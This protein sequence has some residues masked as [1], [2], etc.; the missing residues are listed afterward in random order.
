MKRNLITATLASAVLGSFVMAP[1]MADDN[2]V[3]G[4]PASERSMGDA[5]DDAAIVAKVKAAM[6]SSSE[7]EGLDVNVDSRNGIVTLSGSADSMAER[8]QAERI[9]K[10]A[11]GVKSVDNKIVIKADDAP[12]APR[13]APAPAAT[14][15]D[16]TPPAN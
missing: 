8:S 10:T 3:D 13:T 5:M 14:P 4:A 16:V 11:D 2:A 15:A 6:L 7:V 1:A 12:T 9:A